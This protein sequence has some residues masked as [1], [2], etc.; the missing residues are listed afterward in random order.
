MSPILQG[1]TNA[2]ILNHDGPQDE[3]QD[4][5]GVGKSS[6]LCYNGKNKKEVSHDSKRMY[7]NET[8]YS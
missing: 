3:T 8:Q 2:C 5:K 6:A 7:Y 4:V 1:K